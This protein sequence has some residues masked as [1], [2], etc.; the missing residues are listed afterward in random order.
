MKKLTMV[1]SLVAA[2]GC[3]LLAGCS[4]SKEA[5][6]E[7]KSGTE[8][9]TAEQSNEPVELKVKWQVGKRYLQRMD[10]TQGTESS[11]PNMPQPVKTETKQSQ[12]YAV[13]SLKEL[14][15]GGQEL[16]MEFVSQKMSTKI[17]DREIMG[18]DSASDAKDDGSNPSATA[19]RRMVGAK[20]KFQ[21]DTQGKVVKVEGT[22][23]LMTK[24]TAGS[25]PQ[26]QQM[27][28]G[29]FNDEMLKHMVSLQGLP[30]KAVK[31]GDSWPLTTEIDMP[32]V[33]TLVTKMN[34]TFTGWEQHDK[35]KCA[36]IT[37]T[38]DIASKP[39]APQT[40]G[41]TINIDSGK[42]S[43]KSWFDPAAGMSLGSDVDQSMTMKMKLQGKDIST[44]LNQKIVMKLVEVADV[45]K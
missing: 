27:F 9:A 1:V 37:F 10:M 41:M 28:K 45:G 24:V 14:T 30:D 38:G 40:A 4:K 17:G 16:E 5:K 8:K 13:S 31:V 35:K 6:S 19:L 39:G 36:V 20:L 42:S 23:E 26:M 18:F 34:Y 12:E 3:I 29:M 2:T 11:V 15:G 33:G 44:A 7:S 43:G 22:K 25:A 32:M 21:T